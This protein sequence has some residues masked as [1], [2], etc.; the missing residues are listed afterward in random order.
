[1][2]FDDE[3]TAAG[4]Q[5]EALFGPSEVSEMLRASYTKRETCGSAFAKFYARALSELGIIFLDPLDPELHAIA[6]PLFRS[7]LEKSQELIRAL[8]KR[9]Q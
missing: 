1:M 4:A 8:L 3:I 9:N 2:R 7:A 6:R 5:V